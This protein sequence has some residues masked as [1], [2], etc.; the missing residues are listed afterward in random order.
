MDANGNFIFAQDANGDTLPDRDANGVV[1]LDPNGIAFNED[2]S[3]NGWR[4]LG[5]S[6]TRASIQ[7]SNFQ[8]RDEGDDRNL[9]LA[10]TADFTVPY[11]EG[12]EGTS[13]VT[14]MRSEDLDRSS[15]SLSFSAIEQGLN[16]DVLNDRAAC[17]NPFAV[18][19]P[20]FATSVNVMDQIKT[21]FKERNVTELQ[22]FDL[23]LNGSIPQLTL[24]GGK[25]G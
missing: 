2:V 25:V 9:R 18:V 14:W 16:C 4:P 20:Q 10:F 17:F 12:W 22:T 24:P 1:I 21:A 11:V 15:Q 19:D 23:I 8:T 5:K 6:N 13:F 7:G 3:F